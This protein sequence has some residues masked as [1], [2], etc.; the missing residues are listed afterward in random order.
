MLR[1]AAFA[2]ALSLGVTRG[3]AAQS[4]SPPPPAPD[5]AQ[6]QADD[7]NPARPVLFSLRP[8]WYSR[9]P[10]VTQAAVILRY[11]QLMLRGRPWVPGRRAILRFE[12]PTTATRVTGV[13]TQ[14]G[15]GDAY[16]QVLLVPSLS[17]R[18]ALVAG[19]GVLIPTASDSLLGSGKVALAPAVGP[20][21]FF[22]PRT[23]L[24]VKVQDF[25]SIAGDADRPDFH[26]LLITPIWLHAIGR[27]WWVMLDTETKTNWEDDGRTGVKSGVQVGRAF[28]GRFGMWVK[29]EVWWG[30]NQS[31]QWNLKIG[32]VWH[33]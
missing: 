10:D 5:A 26:Y 24:F 8:E 21:V 27:Q 32:L 23:L 18:V 28:K 4:S 25:V 2:L 14:A 20:L 16:A 33:R 11:D 15:I 19:T 7:S 12:L 6:E 29:P 13:P 22:G 3:A 1:G 17:R 31:G 30:P 9:T